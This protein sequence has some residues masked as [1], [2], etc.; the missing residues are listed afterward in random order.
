MSRSTKNR[1]CLWNAKDSPIVLLSSA[2]RRPSSRSTFAG[3]LGKYGQPAVGVITGA[4]IAVFGTVIAS[5][6]TA[7]VIASAATAAVIASA[8]TAA[9]IA[10]A[11][12]ATV[13][14]GFVPPHCDYAFRR[15]GDGG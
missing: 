8:A 6:A 9:V 10:F 1:G 12:A 14:A 3:V 15:R 5:A 11:A 7:A 4:S 13:V 2:S